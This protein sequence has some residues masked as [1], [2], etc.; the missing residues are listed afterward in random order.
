MLNTLSNNKKLKNYYEKEITDEPVLLSDN[1]DCEYK[2]NCPY[3][4]F[5][6]PV[7][8]LR[9]NEILLEKV[10]QHEISLASALN[11]IDALKE[12]IS[13]LQKENE[14]FKGELKVNRKKIFKSGRKKDNLQQENKKSSAG[15]KK[16]KKYNVKGNSRKRSQNIDEIIDIYPEKCACG[17]TDIEIY[18]NYDEH[19]IEDIEIVIKVKCYR[20]HQGYCSI[21]KKV[22]YGKDE[23]IIPNIM[24]GENSRAIAGY[25]RYTAGVPYLKVKKTFKDLFNLDLS[26]ASLVNFDKKFTENGKEM[27]ETIQGMVKTSSYIHADETG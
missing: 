20:Q 14:I 11:E 12:K 7:H 17:N 23:L 2:L 8:I 9:D 13:K 22:I 24:I 18:D 1:Y 16:G 25:L 27:Y 4:D 5:K 10:E 21:C 15:R 6:S 19:V 26:S 3:A